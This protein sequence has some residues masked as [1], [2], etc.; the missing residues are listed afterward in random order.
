MLTEKSYNY[1]HYYSIPGGGIEGGEKPDETIC[2]EF[3][4]EAG[5]AVLNA[6]EIVDVFSHFRGKNGVD[7][8]KFDR[9]FAVS[10]DEDCL[11]WYTEIA[12]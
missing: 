8:E 7:M 1:L 6:E 2:R 11:R 3:L 9:F 10:V 5:Y 12:E 4:E